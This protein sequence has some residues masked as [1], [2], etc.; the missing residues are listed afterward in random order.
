M[1]APSATS[2]SIQSYLGGRLSAADSRAFEERLPGDPGLVRTMEDT[3]RLREGLELLR[4]RGEL[5]VLVRGPRR[6]RSYWA[7]G[8]ALAAGIASVAVFL[9][10][11]FFAHAPIVTASIDP[12]ASHAGAAS[13]VTAR[14][15]FAAMRQ[16]ISNPDFDLPSGGVLELRVLATGAEPTRSY[17]ATLTLVPDASP[18]ATI[19]TAAR[20]LADADGFVTLYADAAR[21]QPGDYALSVAPES[22]AA[23][24]AAPFRFHLRRAAAPAS[25]IR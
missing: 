12:L 23:A 14:Y 21:L 22:G 8:S 11:Q 25:E 13:P 1:T 20:L 9:G 3:L 7:F 10:L 15:T 4:E 24:S 17:R 16:A 18:A 2:E 6:T 19:G 5:A